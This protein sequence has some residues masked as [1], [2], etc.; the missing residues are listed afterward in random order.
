MTEGESARLYFLAQLDQIQPSLTKQGDPAL[1]S[2]R[3]KLLDRFSE[4]DRLSYDELFRLCEECLQLF[5]EQS[6]SIRVKGE[7]PRL[8]ALSQ[9]DQMEAALLKASTDGELAEDGQQE[10]FQE[11]LAMLVELR[12]LLSNPQNTQ[13][14]VDWTQFDRLLAR[15][16]ELVNPNA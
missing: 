7:V 5:E 13:D 16:G 2:R 10:R 14:N 15:F 1:E 12:R 9:L 11:C 4:R 8:T 6:A 3:R